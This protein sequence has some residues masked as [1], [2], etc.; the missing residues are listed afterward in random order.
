M[1]TF[2]VPGRPIPYVR[3]TRRGKYVTDGKH[4]ERVQAYLNYHA[5]V[6]VIAKAAGVP[7]LEGELGIAVYTR[8]KTKRGGGDSS[9]YRKA[10]EDALQGI[11]FK[12][13]KQITFGVDT[14]TRGCPQDE[15]E[16][17]LWQRVARSDGQI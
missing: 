5:W 4:G 9:N 6:A 2:I 10:I 13:D 8:L 1:I 12:N 15:V 17:R 14:V 7:W 16:I 3:M 11:C